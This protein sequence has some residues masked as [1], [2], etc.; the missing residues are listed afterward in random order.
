MLVAGFGNGIF[1]LELLEVWNDS[2][3]NQMLPKVIHT[4]L[5]SFA[6]NHSFLSY[7]S[8]GCNLRCIDVEFRRFVRAAQGINEVPSMQ[9]ECLANY[10]AELSLLEYSMLSYA[11]SLM[12][13]SSIFLANFVLQ[14]SK[15]PWVWLNQATPSFIM[16]WNFQLHVSP[17]YLW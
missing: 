5:L 17:R 9:L 13:A 6:Q 15:R 11:P 7:T 14:P 2:P 3:D 16:V 8:L 10:I 12:A 4:F 1:G